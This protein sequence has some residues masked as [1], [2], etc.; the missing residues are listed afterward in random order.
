MRLLKLDAPVRPIPRAAEVIS[1][2]RAQDKNFHQSSRALLPVRA[3]RHI[4]DA[5]EGPEKID[6]IEI[7]PYV[8]A[9]NRALHQCANRLPDLAVGRFEHLFGS[10]TSALSTGAMI[11]FAAM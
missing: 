11:C 8:A 5:D 3:G 10:P 4:G 9:L 2:P 7:L 1:W 6:G